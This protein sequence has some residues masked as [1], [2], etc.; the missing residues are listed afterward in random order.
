MASETLEPSNQRAVWNG[1]GGRGWVALQGVLDQLFQPIED[2]VVDAISAETS[3]HVLDIGCGTGSTTVAVARRTGN[4]STGVDISELMIAAA[5]ARA[6]RAGM[7]ASFLVA[8]AQGYPFETAGF[9]A[10]LSRFG[11]MFFAD[12]VV[13]F[14]NLRRAAKAGAPLRAVVWRSAAENP[15]MTTAEHAAAPLLPELPVR[16]PNEP[17]QFGFADPER[18]RGILGASGW[19]KIALRPLDV[20]CKMPADALVPYLTNLGPV[21]R[22][23]QNGNDE[24]R[25]R[26]V[27]AIRPAFDPYVH[28]AEVRFTAACWLISAS[29]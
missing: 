1:A 24:L 7:P 2:L 11:V 23:L 25:A 20:A 22:F 3:G 17:G 13:A 26:V 9:D 16:Q 21:G 18:V 6:E 19:S 5:R 28:G 29:A 12:S 10:I 15:F 27:A 8:D 14:S 4:R